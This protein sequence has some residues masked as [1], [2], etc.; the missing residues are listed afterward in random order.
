MNIEHPD[1]TMI[2]RTGYP[3]NCEE[4]DEVYVCEVCENEIDYDDVYEDGGEI[5][6]R[7]CLLERYR[8]RC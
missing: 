4:E 1:I 8:K 5:L 7:H 3:S 2:R 6:C